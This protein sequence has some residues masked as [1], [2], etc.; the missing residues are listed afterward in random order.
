MS[1]KQQGMFSELGKHVFI[2]LVLATAFFPLFIHAQ[3][4]FWPQFITLALTYLVI[5]GLFLSAYGLGAAW[6]AR[7]LQGNNRLWLARVSAVLIIVAAL[8]LGA[9]TLPAS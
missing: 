6:L 1:M 5:D 8:A 9:R 7:H 3:Q 2:L 4:P